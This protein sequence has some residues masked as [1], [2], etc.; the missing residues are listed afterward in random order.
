M[1][2]DFFLS[3][4]GLFQILLGTSY[5]DK[6]LSF[7]I[8][9]KTITGILLKTIQAN[10]YFYKMSYRLSHGAVTWDVN[11]DFRLLSAGLYH[12]A[13]STDH[14]LSPCVS[15]WSP[16]CL[17]CSSMTCIVQ[18]AVIIQKVSYFSNNIR[19]SS[20]MPPKRNVE[21]LSAL[22]CVYR[23]TWLYSE[24]ALSSLGGLRGKT[25][26]SIYLNNWGRDIIKCCG[27]WSFD[28]PLTG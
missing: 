7:L 17:N 18:A 14:T 6:F 28:T 24:L 20:C 10:R 4:L 12:A 26:H 16:V 19:P 11:C 2:M 23:A 8:V 3:L 1:R 22:V 9:N 27:K 13:K 21:S 15:S 5:F 25:Q